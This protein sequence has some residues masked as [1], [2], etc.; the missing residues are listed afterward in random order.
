MIL[1]IFQAIEVALNKTVSSFKDVTKTIT[2]KQESAVNSL[3]VK[4]LDDYVK[5]NWCYSA[6][7]NTSITKNCR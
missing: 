4:T 1:K 6:K 3:I 2:E 5:K 7:P